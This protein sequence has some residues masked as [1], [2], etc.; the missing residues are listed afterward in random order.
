MEKYKKTVQEKQER[1]YEEKYEEL[2]LWKKTQKT[3]MF[4]VQEIGTKR[5][6]MK[7]SYPLEKAKIYGKL[8]KQHHKNILMIKE[9]IIR[10]EECI[11]IE[12]FVNGTTLTEHLSLHKDGKISLNQ[13]LSWCSAICDGLIWLHKVGIIHRDINQNNVMITFDG[14]VKLC[15]FDIARVYQQGKSVDTEI[16]GT[17]GSV[18]PEQYGYGQSSNKSDI[19]AVGVLLNK[20]LTGKE[21][22][23][24]IYSGNIKVQKII[25][26]A[27]ALDENERFTNALSLKHALDDALKKREKF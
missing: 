6:W 9:V 26:I 24:E 20:M 4:L 16:L 14:I 5:V 11:V 2:A 13:A 21:I 7:K 8:Q 19:Y 18:A 25:K 12:E 15:D 22:D 3:T 1:K 23:E 17:Q 27:T 10:E